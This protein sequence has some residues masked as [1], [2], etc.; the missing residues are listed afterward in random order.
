MKINK[1]QLNM[2]SKW[3]YL[4]FSYKRSVGHHIPFLINRFQWHYFPKLRHVS[5]FPPHVDIE[6]S[7]VCN[8][9]C[10]M[11]YT[12]TKDFERVPKKLMDFEL[13]KKIIDECAQYKLYSIRLSLRGEPF[14]HPKI[15]DMIEYA[16]KKGI[17]EVSSLSNNLWLTPEKFKKLMDMDFDWLTISFDGLGKI[18]E[19]IRK[20]A[21]FEESLEKIRQYHE[22][23]KQS[24]KV[25]PV[26]KVQTVWSAIQDNPLE[27]YNT[28]KPITDNVSTNPLIDYLHN[29]KDIVYEKNFTCPVPWQRLVIG[30]DGQVLMCSNDEFNRHILGNVNESSI[31]S[32]WH[33]DKM[34]EI[35]QIHKEHRGVELLKPC[36]YCYVP[37]VT[38]KKEIRDKNKVFKIDDY[39]YRNQEDFWIKKK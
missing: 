38:E 29:D 28:F 17:K 4:L 18:Y 15:F 39:I 11:C 30:S 22:L 20:P 1:G 14:M 23:K 34:S 6:T 37:R 2:S 12:Q 25:K 5:K 16:K 27:F 35:R 13:F 9:N 10:P 31:Y 36:K 7:T 19:K 21:K 3:D 8:L 32:I 24:G 33:G 26:V